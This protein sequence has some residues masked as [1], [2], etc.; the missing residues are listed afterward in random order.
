MLTKSDRKFVTQ[1]AFNDWRAF[2]ADLLSKSLADKKGPDE[3]ARQAVLDAMYEVMDLVTPW[4]VTGDRIALRAHEDRLEKIFTEAA[5]LAQFLRRQRALWSTRFP[6]R[7]ILPGLQ[8]T[9]PLMF[10]PSSMKDER[11]DDEDIHP[12]QL[13]LRYVDIVVTTALYK[14]GNTNGEKFESE[15]AAAPAM[16]V[17]RLA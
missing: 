3:N 12:E 15:E 10:D 8:E 17:M 5:Q 7:P 13:K 1:R 9:G 14:R 16:V 11:G 4:C 6:S 2:T